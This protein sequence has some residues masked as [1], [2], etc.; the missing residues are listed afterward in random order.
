MM[1]ATVKQNTTIAYSHHNSRAFAASKMPSAKY[2]EAMLAK[3]KC[4]V[5]I[6]LHSVFL[7]GVRV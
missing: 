6:N 5:T 4:N 2:D 7:T 3:T 1:S